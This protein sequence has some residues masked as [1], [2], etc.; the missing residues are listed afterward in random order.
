MLVKSLGY[1]LMSVSMLC[2]LDLAV[3]FGKYGCVVFMIS[4]NSTVFSGV[5]KGDLYIVDFSEG[6]QVA[7]CLM[8]RASE[9]WLWHQRL[10]HA[11]ILKGPAVWCVR[12]WK[13]DQGQTS[14]ED[15]HDY[16]KTS[17]ISSHGSIRSSKVFKLWR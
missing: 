1:N 12:G 14:S 17:G 15:H 5:R 7:T 10:G 3:L 11:G 6:L 9:C 2:D 13:D 4:D 16:Y 8:A